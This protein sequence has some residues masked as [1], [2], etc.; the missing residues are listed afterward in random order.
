ML[1][2]DLAVQHVAVLLAEGRRPDHGTE[3]R[4]DDVH[5]VRR[6]ERLPLFLLLLLPQ[7]LV[8][9]IRHACH[10][11]R[12]LRLH[13]GSNK[14][15]RSVSMIKHFPCYGPLVG[16]VIGCEPDSV[17]QISTPFMF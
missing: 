7:E 2:S 5:Q 6:G 17:I 14:V 1:Y 15:L 10:H 13:S 4:L 8:I 3:P 12:A 16:D 9:V 11:N